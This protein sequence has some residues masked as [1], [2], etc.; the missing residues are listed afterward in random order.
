VRCCAVIIWIF[1]PHPPPLGYLP[2]VIIRLSSSPPHPSGFVDYI[3]WSP[4]QHVS[5]V[6]NIPHKRHQLSSFCV[7][8][9]LWRLAQLFYGRGS[10]FLCCVLLLIIPGRTVAAAAVLGLIFFACM[11]LIYS[12]ELR[13]TPPIFLYFASIRLLLCLFLTVFVAVYFC[14]SF[15]EMLL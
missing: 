12:S 11:F 15:F 5:C 6:R 9:Y 14:V 4:A 13:T 10:R 8:L 7:F 3:L 2:G 1:S